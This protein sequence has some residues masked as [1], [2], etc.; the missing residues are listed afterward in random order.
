MK[1]FYKFFFIFTCGF[2]IGAIWYRLQLFPI[3]QLKHIKSHR[4]ETIT[5]TSGEEIFVD[6][7]YYDHSNNSEFDNMFLIKLT[8]HRNHNDNIKL[9][10]K[11]PITIYRILSKSNENNFLHSFESTSIKVNVI[12]D[13]SSHTEV[14]KRDFL[15]GIIE[16]SPG[17]GLSSSPILISHFSDKKK[18]DEIFKIIDSFYN[19][20]K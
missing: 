5:Y 11:V 4:T 9:E 14:V 1:S 18:Q 6:R 3:P 19:F 20:R 12:G 10:V 15:P 13:S 8:R 7:K 17:K 2:L 16:L